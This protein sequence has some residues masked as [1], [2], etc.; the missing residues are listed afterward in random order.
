[1]QTVSIIS[2]A[3]GIFGVKYGT[4]S[5]DDLIMATAL[6]LGVMGLMLV[7]QLLRGFLK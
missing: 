5:Y 1:M 4:T 3:E 7:I 6:L 2:L